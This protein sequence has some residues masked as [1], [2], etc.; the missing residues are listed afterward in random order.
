MTEIFSQQAHLIFFL[1]GNASNIY[2]IW[3]LL[4]YPLKFWLALFRPQRRPRPDV[5]TGGKRYCLRSIYT[6][7]IFHNGN[8]VTG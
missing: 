8:I 4:F 2:H 1:F 5:D 3:F 7:K 6:D